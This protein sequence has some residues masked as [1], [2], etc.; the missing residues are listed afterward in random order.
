M[1]TVDHMFENFV[2]SFTFCF[3]AWMI[4]GSLRRYLVAR[5]RTAIQE[6]VFTRLDSTQS[7]LELANNDT[8]RRFF[9]SLTIERAEPVSPYSRI[10]YGMQAGI[11]LS[12]LG[13][14]FLYLHHVKVTDGPELLIFGAGSVALGLGFLLAAGVSLWFSRQ[15]GL[16]DRD[17]SR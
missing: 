8:G 4:F 14:A 17:S 6:K 12:S 5:S 13:A 15:F 7:L 9:E 3:I 16:L 10:L 11:V 1:N 2:V